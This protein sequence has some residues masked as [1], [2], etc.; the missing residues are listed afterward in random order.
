MSCA[1]LC[2]PSARLFQH[3]IRVLCDYLEKDNGA[4]FSLLSILIFSNCKAKLGHIFR[5]AEYLRVGT[6]M[7]N[8]NVSH[9]FDAVVMQG[10]QAVS[11]LP[12]RSVFTVEV[13]EISRQVALSAD[14]V[15]GRRQPQ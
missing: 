14:R 6:S 9:G 7:I 4:M 12:F 15:T 5:P 3:D 13:V 8:H 11:Q 1:V 2:I 10:A